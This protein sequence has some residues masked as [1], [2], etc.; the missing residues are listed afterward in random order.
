MRVLFCVVIILISCT[1]NLWGQAQDIV[2]S[3]SAKLPVVSID[4]IRVPASP[5]FKLLGE[6]PSS[7]ERPTDL[8][9]L[10]I[11]IGKLFNE[12]NVLPK[13]FA[14]EFAPAALIP[15]FK[16]DL[17]EYYY[18]NFCSST[19][20]N[21]S[22]SFATSSVPD[23]FFH[24]SSFKS[25]KAL[26]FGFRTQFISGQY[27][28]SEEDFKNNVYS[29][30]LNFDYVAIL[31]TAVIESIV[32]DKKNEALFS[33]ISKPLVIENLD[34]F[35]FESSYAEEASKR[36]DPSI[37]DRFRNA[38]KGPIR[39]LVLEFLNEY[40]DSCKSNTFRINLDKFLTTWSQKNVLN[41]PIAIQIRKN[42][43]AGLTTLEGKT[44]WFWEVAFAISGVSPNDEI[45]HK[46]SNRRW[47]TWTTVSYRPGSTSNPEVVG[48][49]RLLN[50]KTDSVNWSHYFDLGIRFISPREWPISLS[51]EYVNRNPFGDNND[52]RLALIAEYPLS[53]GVYLTATVGKGFD[54]EL[55]AQSHLLSILGLKFGAGSQKLT[56]P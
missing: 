29:L 5:A 34:T 31:T 26:S 45:S 9:S 50:N 3:K 10:A 17:I 4:S 51:V 28:I 8:K 48:V 43:G 46:L 23:G 44:G 24:D 33:T 22:L 12:N 15:P 27:K 2:D 52:H 53:T 19:W 39:K 11:D 16:K 38:R 55:P 36:D 41:S 42:I 1:G 40:I 56:T 30:F 14:M 21:L 37:S 18:P 35:H 49:C 13:S 54:L 20:Q 6:E 47:G 25:T 7:V 32:F